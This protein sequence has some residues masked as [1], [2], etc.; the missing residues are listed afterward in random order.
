MLLWSPVGSAACLT[1]PLIFAGAT[2]TAGF[3]LQA[4]ECLRSKFPHL[5]YLC[6]QETFGFMLEKEP[7]REVLAVER[8]MFYMLVFSSIFTPL[9]GK[10]VARNTDYFNV[11]PKY[12]MLS[13]ISGLDF[14][15]FLALCSPCKARTPLP[16]HRGL[17]LQCAGN[18]KCQ[19]K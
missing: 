16:F 13:K 4:P 1:L 6:F 5:W 9:G 14:G 8:D 11:M 7:L 18:E 10:S 19:I 2:G 3:N 17:S 15:R 12:K